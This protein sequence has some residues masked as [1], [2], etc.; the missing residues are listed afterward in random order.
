VFAPLP[1]V[2]KGGR[3]NIASGALS[4]H[5]DALSLKGLLAGAGDAVSGDL[6]KQVRYL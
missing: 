2:L 3:A 6:A 5:Q 4:L 1:Q